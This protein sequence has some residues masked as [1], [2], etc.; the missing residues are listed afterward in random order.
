VTSDELRLL[1]ERLSG[2]SDD[3]TDD[4]SLTARELDVLAQVAL[5]C[6]NGEVARRLSLRPETV[7]SYLRSASGKLGSRTRHEAV[8]RARSRGLLP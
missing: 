6:T 1:A 3:T 5:G 2:R 8:S 4:A 7:K